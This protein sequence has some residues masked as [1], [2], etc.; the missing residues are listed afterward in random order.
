MSVDS[1][2]LCA[3]EQAYGRSL[4]SCACLAWVDVGVGIVVGLVRDLPFAGL[5]VGIVVEWVRGVVCSV[6]P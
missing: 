4:G 3:S 1:V 2:P 5:V 6:W